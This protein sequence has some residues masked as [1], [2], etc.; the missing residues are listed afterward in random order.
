MLSNTNNKKKKKQKGQKN[1]EWVHIYLYIVEHMK[2][3]NE[4]QFSL[5][6]F[7]F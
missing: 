3:L 2:M 7:G 4:E 1:P 5:L 6:Y